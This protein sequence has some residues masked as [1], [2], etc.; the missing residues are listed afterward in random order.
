MKVRERS[1]ATAVMIGSFVGGGGCSEA[2]DEGDVGGAV[3][4]ILDALDDAHGERCGVALEVD[5]SL[6]ALHSTIAMERGYVTAEGQASRQGSRGRRRLGDAGEREEMF[7][8]IGSLFVVPYVM[9]CM[10]HHFTCHLFI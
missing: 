7:T 6:E 3:G 2:V 4:V 8:V 5:G 10:I 9:S 1:S